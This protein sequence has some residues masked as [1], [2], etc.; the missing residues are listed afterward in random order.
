MSAATESVL[1]TGA[2][3]FLGSHLVRALLSDDRYHALQILAL[4]DLSGGFQ[5]NLPES[6]RVSFLPISITDAAAV[7]RVFDE[8]RIRF[9]FHL[10][11]YAAEGLS[12][13]IRRFNYTNNLI[14]IV[15]LINASVVSGVQHFVF[16]SSIA[17]YGAARVPMRE[18][19]VP[20]PEDHY[21]ISKL[22][23]E[24]ELHAAKAQFGL[25]Y[26]IFRPH[27]VYGEFQNLGDRY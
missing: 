19:M 22:A 16:T 21:G 1:V 14:G 11:A 5:E 10:A 13:F 17:V 12:H 18:D 9:V 20:A 3:G 7:D 15:N 6:S 4:D 24:L 25:K 8:H 23:V 26:T 2:A 27:N